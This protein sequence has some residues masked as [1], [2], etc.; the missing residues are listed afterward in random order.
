MEVIREEPLKVTPFFLTS[1]K[2]RT[3]EVVYRRPY[4]IPICY[5]EA[6][7]KQLLELEQQGIIRSSRSP[8]CAPLI[9][10]PKKDEGL[11]LCLD[12]CALNKTLR[13]ERFPLPN[14]NTLLNQLGKRKIFTTLDLKQGY[15]QIPLDK[16][17]C[18]KT[19]F[20]SPAGHWEFMAL[21]LGLKMAPIVLPENYQHSTSRINR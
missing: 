9:P 18:E 10:V 12:F 11:R 19:A 4:N 7:N 5:H 17:S 13:D 20:S 15:H 16:S 21:P 14:I 1:I 6:V 8:F 3:E 2:Q